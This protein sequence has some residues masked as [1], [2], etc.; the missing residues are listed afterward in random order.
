MPVKSWYLE[1]KCLSTS[2][3]QQHA[4]KSVE[5]YLA[6]QRAESKKYTAEFKN[7]VSTRYEQVTALLKDYRQHT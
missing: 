4:V 3:F 1:V 6:G 2:E 5:H 7:D